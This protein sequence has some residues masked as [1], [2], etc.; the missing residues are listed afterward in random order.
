MFYYFAY[1]E[2]VCSIAT[3][4]AEE[5]VGVDLREDVKIRVSSVLNGDATQFGKQFLCDGK[6]DTC[7]NSEQGSPQF[8]EMK[9]DD[10]QVVKQLKIMFQG[11]FAGKNCIV[12][13]K[14]SKDDEYV[15]LGRFFPEDINY[16]QTFNDIN[17]NNTLCSYLKITFADST[18]FY[19]RITIYTLA[20]NVQRN[21]N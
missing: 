19:G 14:R 2:S 17:E 6:E 16:E 4:M 11:G 7:W 13:G 3:E 18:D 8:I 9:F 10:P 21:H 1:Q 12:E 5:V 15:E 20:V